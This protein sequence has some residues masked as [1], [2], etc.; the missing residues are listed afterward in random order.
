MTTASAIL[1]LPRRRATE[2][3]AATVYVALAVVILALVLLELTIGVVQ[4]PLVS[5]LQF[6]QSGNSGQDSWDRILWTARLPRLVNAL[7][8]GAGLGVCGVL[9]QTLFRNPLADPYVMGTVHGGRLGV[10]T[11]L[12][13]T[14]VIGPAFGGTDLWGAIG[15]PAAAAIGSGTVTLVLALAARRLERAALLIFGLM[16]GFS[17]LALMDVALVFAGDSQAGV[18]RFWDHGNFNGA[19]WEQLSVML[20]VLSLA[21]ILAVSQ[22]KALNA[23]VLSE[24]YAASMG[25][26]VLRARIL[27]FAAASVLAGIVTA[28][29][30]PVAFLGL[31][32]AQISRV[33]LRTGDHRWLLPAAL[34]FGAALAL[35]ADFVSH[36]PWKVEPP[37]LDMLMGVIGAPVIIWSLLRKKNRFA[38]EF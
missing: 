27:S 13:V 10:A 28:Y 2:R 26:H 30:G 6:F 1:D 19:T 38:L 36:L 8:S 32:V 14:G 31:I 21:T 7:A 17:C 22:V 34:L 25:V 11:L 16:L 24:E 20:P 12:A 4:I 37:H 35:A 18:F 5:I 29:S 3:K 33:V 15:L 23:L 9:L